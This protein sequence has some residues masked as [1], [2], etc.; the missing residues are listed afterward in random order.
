MRFHRTKA[1][2]TPRILASRG[3]GL[4]KETPGLHRE[5]GFEYHFVIGWPTMVARWYISVKGIALNFICRIFLP[6][7]R[8]TDGCIMAC[9][10]V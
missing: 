4:W 2:Q 10:Y 3:W 9:V 8:Y 1:I 5:R 7:K 6:E